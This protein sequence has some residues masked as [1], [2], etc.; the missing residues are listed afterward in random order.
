MPVQSLSSIF[1]KGPELIRSL[2]RFFSEIDYLT[3]QDSFFPD[4]EP[5]VAFDFNEMIDHIC[6]LAALAAGIVG[7]IK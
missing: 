2:C 3:N 6:P 7:A 5:I 1:F 4:Q